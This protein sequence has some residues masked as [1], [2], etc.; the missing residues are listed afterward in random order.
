M[1]YTIEREIRR[2]Y[3]VAVDADDIDAA[4]GKISFMAEPALGPAIEH[5]DVTKYNYVLSSIHVCR[6]ER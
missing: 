6:E 1:L 5:S 4:V 2:R 3:I